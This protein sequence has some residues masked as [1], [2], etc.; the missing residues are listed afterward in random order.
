[1]AGMAR[2]PRQLYAAS[3]PEVDAGS[4]VEF[5]AM[6][7]LQSHAGAPEKSS[8]GGLFTGL[9]SPHAEPPRRGLLLAVAV[10][11][12]LVAGAAIVML[13]RTRHS[14]GQALNTQLPPDAYAH[15]LVFTQLAMSQSTSLSGG[16]STFLDGH[17]RNS[18][19]EIVTGIVVQAI[20][21][22]DVGL[23]P[24]IDTLPLFLIRTHQPYVDTEPVSATPLKPGDDVEF[25]LIF[26]TIP[27]NWN[28][29]MPEIL[30][31]RIAKK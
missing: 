23:A 14:A 22:N 18:G 11:L 13:V 6:S 15:K 1:M 24:Q 12:V 27:S 25:R 21:R 16:T 9:S 28:Q 30:P 20:F 26:E 29:Q 8:G 5:Q 3:L 31:I 7:D 19:G 17:I 4:R 2:Q 10:A